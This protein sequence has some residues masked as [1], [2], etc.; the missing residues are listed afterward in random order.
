MNDGQGD[1]RC[2]ADTRCLSIASA[3]RAHVII[4]QLGTRDKDVYK[5]WLKGFCDLTWLCTASRVRQSQQQSVS[6]TD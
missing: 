2:I 5:T 6:T 4:S 1:V 3:V